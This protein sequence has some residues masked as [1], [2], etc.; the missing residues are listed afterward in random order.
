MSYSVQWRL[1]GLSGRHLDDGCLDER[2][3]DYGSA[4]A[5]VDSFLRTYA[6]VG[7]DDEGRHWRAR[8]S[9]D[10]DIEMEV[11]VERSTDPGA[12]VNAGLRAAHH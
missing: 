2:F 5:A 1:V 6:E 10:A 7:R 8:R 11:W 12:P 4:V 3:A 9:Q